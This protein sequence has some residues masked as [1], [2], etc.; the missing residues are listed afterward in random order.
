MECIYQML[1]KKIPLCLKMLFRFEN[2]R[3]FLAHPVYSVGKILR[4]FI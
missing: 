2:R 4:V 3:V 1:K